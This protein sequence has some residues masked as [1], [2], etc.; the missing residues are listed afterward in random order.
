MKRFA[1]LEDLSPW[2]KMALLVGLIILFALLTALLGLLL[3]KYY[4]DV[5][6]MTLAAMIENPESPEAVVF[7]KWYQFINQI[8]F[9]IIP[10]VVFCYYVSVSSLD[11]LKLKEQPKS[12]SVLISIMLVYTALPFLNYV[13]ELN[14]QMSLPD[15]F[16]G[17][18]NW[19]KDREEQAQMLTSSFLKAETIPILLLNLLI[20]AV[21]PAIGEEILFRGVVLKLFKEIT[22]NIHLAVFISA[23]LFSALHLQFYGFLPR[24]LLGMLLG[25][26]FVYTRNMWVP[27]LVHFVNNASSVIIFYLHH[28]GYIKV[29]MEDFGSTAN[30]AYIIGSL[31]LSLWLI[32]I[33]YQKEQ[34]IG[35]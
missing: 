3:G 5:D 25:Y 30:P 26:L 10:V 9:F 15:A 29:S 24:L 2:L 28:N 7:I 32:Q 13:G 18:E 6:L 22:K 8:G 35:A 1:Y 4:F 20:V 34:R 14:Q 31:L 17:L 19:M 27:I 23:V 11:Y 21:V 16:T 33:L 12:V